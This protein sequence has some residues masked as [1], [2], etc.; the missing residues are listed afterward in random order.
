MTILL[1]VMLLAYLCGITVEAVRRYR[2]RRYSLSYLLLTMS[3]VLVISLTAVFFMKWYASWQISI[4]SVSF[5]LLGI[6]PQAY[7]F[8]HRLPVS[9]KRH[10]IQFAW[11]ILLISLFILLGEL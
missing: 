7:E 9:L 3:L 8:Q 10:L 5:L 11:H 6:L 2:L 1:V 4:L